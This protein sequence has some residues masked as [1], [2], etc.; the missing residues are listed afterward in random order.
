MIRREQ[1]SFLPE[2]IPVPDRGGGVNRHG[3]NDWTDGEPGRGATVYIT[4]KS[5]S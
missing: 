2:S 3:G 1:G 4:L 5:I